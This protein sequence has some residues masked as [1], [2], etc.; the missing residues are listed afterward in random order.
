MKIVVIGSGG[1]EHAIGH[2]LARSSRVQEVISCPGN[3]GLQRLGSCWT[4]LDPLKDTESFIHRCRDEQIDHVVIGPEAPLVAGLADRLR[5]AGIRAFGPSAAAARLEGSKAYS[6]EFME[7]HRIPTAAHRTIT[8]VRDLP[9]ALDQLPDQVVVKASGLAA[10]KGVIVCDDRQQ[11]MVAATAMLV[12][13]SFGESGK[14][15]VLEERMR[16]P[17]VSVLAVAHGTDALVLPTAQDHKPLLDGNLGPNTGGMGAFCPGTI[18]DAADLDIIRR[19]VIEPTL[20]GLCSDGIEYSGVLYAGLMMTESGPRVLEYNCR[21]GDPETQPVLSRLTSDFT[22]ILE[23]TAEGAPSSASV[24]WDPRASLCLV[25]ASEG[26]PAAPRKGQQIRGEVFSEIDDPVQV[27]HAGTVA[28]GDQIN[29]S[30]GRVLGVTALGNS[31]EEARTLAYERAE[32]I[33]FDGKIY[34][35]DIG[36]YQEVRNKTESME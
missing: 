22:E 31:L 23:A 2:Q 28:D 24:S 4:D 1:R 25:L 6:K 18:I 27:F 19:D 20:Q 26:Y 21:L 34:R 35:G 36:T 7:R 32:K 16:G 3:P 10:G 9:A 15:V 29:V 11:A 13:N 12:E 17:E 5:A 30:G 14:T 8:D 33:A